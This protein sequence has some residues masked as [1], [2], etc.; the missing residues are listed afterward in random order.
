M[1][2]FITYREKHLLGDIHGEW[3]VILNHLKKTDFDMNE[4]KD[5]CYIQVGDFAIGYNDVK[6]ELRKL[7]ILNNE[8][9]NHLGI[10]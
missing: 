9:A 7:L 2:N 10:S 5:I 6:V 1:K 4:R 8:L 3:S